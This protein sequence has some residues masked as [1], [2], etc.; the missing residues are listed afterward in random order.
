MCKN[1][2]KKADIPNGEEAYGLYSRSQKPVHN[3][4]PIKAYLGKEFVNIRPN[5]FID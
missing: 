4:N 2:E 3:R 5:Y 1:M